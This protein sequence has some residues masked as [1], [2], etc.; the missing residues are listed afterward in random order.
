MRN[1]LPQR[2]LT[3]PEIIG[4]VVVSFMLLPFLIGG[5]LSLVMALSTWPA[6]LGLATGA[7]GALIVQRALARESVKGRQRIA[8][9]ERENAMLAR[10]VRQLE[11]TVDEFIHPTHDAQYERLASLPSRAPARAPAPAPRP[12]P[13]SPP[14]FPPPPPGGGYGRG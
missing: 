8:E 12:G 5:F 2:P 13:Q 11:A 4:V 1:L 6:V 9:L 3:G 14:P 10:Q 7:G